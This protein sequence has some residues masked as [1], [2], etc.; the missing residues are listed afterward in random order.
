MKSQQYFGSEK[1]DRQVVTHK[2]DLRHWNLS[3]QLRKLEKQP[4]LQHITEP[5]KGTGIDKIQLLN[6]GVEGELGKKKGPIQ[7]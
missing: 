7:S 4:H 6:E 1:G 3:C 2:T 5:P